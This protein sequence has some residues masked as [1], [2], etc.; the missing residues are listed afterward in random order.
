M[1]MLTTLEGTTVTV[2]KKVVVVCPAQRCGEI[3]SDVFAILGSAS[4]LWVD[5]KFVHTTSGIRQEDSAAAASSTVEDSSEDVELKKKCLLD[6]VA[7]SQLR[8]DLLTLL[9][10]GVDADLRLETRDGTVF[11]VHRYILS[12]RCMNYIKS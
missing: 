1:K 7:M 3:P 10:S 12:G 11:D 6:V 4:P 8:K 9:D 5:L 2:E